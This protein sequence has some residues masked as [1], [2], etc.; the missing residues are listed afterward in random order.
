MFRKIFYVLPT[1]FF[2]TTD[3]KSEPYRGV[4]ARI[5]QFLHRVKALKHR[6]FVVLNAPAVINAVLKSK[7]KRIAVPITARGHYVEMTDN[8]D[9]GKSFCAENYFA[10]IAIVINRFEPEVFCERQKISERVFNLF[11]ERRAGYR[12]A[13]RAFIRYKRF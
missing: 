11:A 3:E 13:L 6:T 12:S 5:F 9:F 4:Y 10:R 2:V 8:A 1:G 7:R